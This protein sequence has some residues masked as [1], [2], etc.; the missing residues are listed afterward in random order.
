MRRTVWIIACCALVA[1]SSS[2]KNE[3]ASSGGGSGG[4]AGASGGSGGST[5]GSGGA[6]GGSA[7]A[8]GAGGS[9]GG[10]GG[11]TGG[12]AGL[13]GGGSTPTCTYEVA[14]QTIDCAPHSPSSMGVDAAAFYFALGDAMG[15]EYLFRVSKTAKLESIAAWVKLGNA[16]VVGDI[17]SDGTNVY[18]ATNAPARQL[19]RYAV[20][21]GAETVLVGSADCP[22]PFP[23]APL[24]IDA[25][26]VYFACN[27]SSDWVG[28][29]SG[30]SA[31]TVW[32][33][34]QTVLISGLASNGATLAVALDSLD[35]IPLPSGPAGLL[36]ADSGYTRVGMVG[37]S[38]YA[39]SASSVVKHYLGGAAPE[40]VLIGVPGIIDF[41]VDATG[42]YAILPDKVIGKTLGAVG[43]KEIAT[44]VKPA[45]I[46]LDA[47]HVF[48]TT[49]DGKVQRA[50]R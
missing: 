17:V 9:T 11:S 5:A 43:H 3:A 18:V 44:N 10:A 36:Q 7:G 16:S 39:Q 40:D 15:E 24:A 28:V 21:T 34:P 47:T 45:G 23:R 22:L 30:S 20:N 31:A 50:A 19:V 42:L 26:G 2:S 4:M 41:R 38:V 35:K 8:G 29:W 49:S 12:S 13:D 33:Y 6:T 46:A 37:Q 27:G 1:C 32:T 25:T 14:T 48:W